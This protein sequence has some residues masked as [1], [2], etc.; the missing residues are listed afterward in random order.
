MEFI[1]QEYIFV[2]YNSFL[3]PQNEMVT[4]PIGRTL[5]ATGQ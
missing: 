1:T 3:T 4:K 2:S 5:Y